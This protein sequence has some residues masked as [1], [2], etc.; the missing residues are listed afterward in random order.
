[1]LVFGEFAGHGATTQMLVI[2]GSLI[3]IGGAVA[4]SF[5]E[6]PDSEQKSW[7][8]A[9]ERECARYRLDRHRV[10]LTLEGADPLADERPKRRWWELLIVAA[11][12][13]LFVWLAAAAERPALDVSLP[14]MIVLIVAS[15]ALLGACGLMLWRRTRF[16]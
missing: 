13:A 3:M 14:W 5:A 4:I 10:A 2:A 9:M 1:V 15:L 12:V 11:A 16:S 6:A 7:R 8:Q